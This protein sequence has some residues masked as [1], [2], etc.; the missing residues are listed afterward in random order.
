ML[1]ASLAIRPALADTSP[2]VQPL[3]P[4]AHKAAG[5]LA[6]L[7]AARRAR[8]LASMPALTNPRWEAF[9]QRRAAAVV[10]QETQ[11][12]SVK[13][14]L[15]HKLSPGSILS[16]A[17]NLSARQ[18]IKARIAELQRAAERRLE[19]QLANA[20]AD[21]QIHQAVAYLVNGIQTPI[22]DI[23]EHS[24]LAQE[25]TRDSFTT[26]TGKRARTHTKTTVKSISKIQS[27]T[28]L[29]RMKGWTQEAAISISFPGFVATVRDVTPA[30]QALPAPSPA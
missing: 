1:A 15:G 18:D 27:L 5:F 24:P 30:S 7:P 14:L 17:R 20:S 16:T 2:Q 22:A 21:M 6:P 13:A 9:A 19:K 11:I 8:I 25:V 4:R 12:E 3:S 28:L 10:T 23:D 29:A 26:G